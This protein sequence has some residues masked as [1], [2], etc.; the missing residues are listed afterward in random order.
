[1]LQSLGLAGLDHMILPSSGEGKLANRCIV[2][3]GEL[4][5]FHF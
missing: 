3:N 2:F 1:M 4:R 5:C